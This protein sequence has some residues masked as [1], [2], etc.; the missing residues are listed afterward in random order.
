METIRGALNATFSNSSKIFSSK[1]LKP[2]QGHERE[3]ENQINRSNS[4]QESKFKQPKPNIGVLLSRP[5]PEIAKTKH[6]VSVNT[7]KRNPSMVQRPIT[8]VNQ[9]DISDELRALVDSAKEQELPMAFFDQLVKDDISIRRVF[10]HL[11]RAFH[12]LPTEVAV[13]VVE[14]LVFEHPEVIPSKNAMSEIGMKILKLVNLKT[15]WSDIERCHFSYIY[16][17][18]MYAEEKRLVTCG[19]QKQNKKN[20]KESL[21]LTKSSSKPKVENVN[22]PKIIPKLKSSSINSQL[23]KKRKIVLLDSDESSLDDDEEKQ[24][25]VEVED[26]EVE[27]EEDEDE[28]QVEVGSDEEED[29]VEGEDL[30][31][32]D[33]FDDEDEDDE[34]EDDEDDEN[35]SFIAASEEEGEDIE[36]SSNSESDDSDDDDMMNEKLAYARIDLFFRLIEKEFPNYISKWIYFA[37][38]FLRPIHYKSC[39]NCMPQYFGMK[40]PRKG[41]LESEEVLIKKCFNDNYLAT[42]AWVSEYVI[43]EE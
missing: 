30:D 29:E 10:M 12:T 11:C 42:L 22:S 37:R 13:F 4:S 18:E 26:E 28:D 33:D 5:S 39:I 15:L 19:T 35:D 40:E 8:K 23:K 17:R 9:C 3:K 2:S 20:K 31:D 1:S 21:K 34:D 16:N 36:N 7:T 43:L 25:E 27:D 41:Y 6:V 24:V 14:Y 38:E 32:F